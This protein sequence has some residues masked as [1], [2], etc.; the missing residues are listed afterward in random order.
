M[1]CPRSQAEDSKPTAPRSKAAP[2]KATVALSLAGMLS[3]SASGGMGWSGFS[4]FDATVYTEARILSRLR[5]DQPV[6][7]FRIRIVDKAVLPIENMETGRFQLGGGKIRREHVIVGLLF[8]RPLPGSMRHVIQDRQP[9]ARFERLAD[10]PQ[11][12]LV[13]RH[14]MISVHDQDRVERPWR[15]LRIVVGATN[16]RR[17]FHVLL[18]EISLGVAQ[19]PILFVHDVFAINAAA[20]SHHMRQN[21]REFASAASDIRHAAALMYAELPHNFAHPDF[22]E[23]RVLWIQLFNERL[24]RILRKQWKNDGSEEENPAHA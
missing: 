10:V 13:F 15:K 16:H 23:P 8:A 21:H 6:R 14:F 7:A 12:R 1:A 20:R 5:R 3:V 18:L 19:T 9:A 24:H 2:S 11:H 22:F 4:I 17:I